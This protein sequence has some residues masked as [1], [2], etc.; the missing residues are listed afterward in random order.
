MRPQSRCLSVLAVLLLL[1]GGGDFV[2][3]GLHK[4]NKGTKD[5]GRD[6]SKETGPNPLGRDF[7]AKYCRDMVS[8]GT[9]LGSLRC[10]PE[11]LLGLV[12]P[13]GLPC[14]PAAIIAG[15]QKTGTTVLSGERG[16]DWDRGL[17]CLQL[18]HCTVMCTYC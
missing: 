15:A 14:L 7:E 18:T 2:C 3:G 1:L 8:T 5:K 12:G 16:R 17:A 9:P 11:S 4:N 10:C 6:K 13:A